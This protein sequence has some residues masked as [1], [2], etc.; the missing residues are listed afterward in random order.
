[1]LL[2]RYKILPCFKSAR[3]SC[4]DVNGGQRKIYVLSFLT[5]ACKRMLASLNLK[6]TGQIDCIF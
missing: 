4:S 5:Y 6:F 1:M 2:I 3:V